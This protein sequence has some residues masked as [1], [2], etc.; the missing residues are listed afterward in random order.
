M[1]RP[2]ELAKSALP[3]RALNKPGFGSGRT[4]MLYARRPRLADAANS[5]GAKPY[6]TLN[7]TSRIPES[8]AIVIVASLCGTASRAA[9]TAVHGCLAERIESSRS[10][11]CGDKEK[12]RVPLSLFI[13]SDLPSAA[14]NCP[15]MVSLLPSPNVSN[16]VRKKR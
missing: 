9:P 14:L 8:S 15:S 2:P 4:M 3:S 11:I 5:T 7:A 10:G 13:L 12:V 1:V 16:Q 6:S